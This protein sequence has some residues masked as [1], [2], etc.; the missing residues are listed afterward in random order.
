MEKALK[1]DPELI[2]ASEV[3][4]SMS[5]LHLAAACP[6]AGGVDAVRWLLEKGI[7]W[8][9]KDAKDRIPEDLARMMGNEE[10]CKVLREWAVQKGAVAHI[11]DLN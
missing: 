2:Y 1:K 7:P 4:D 6:K 10:S 11:D 9:A 5:V 3:F 8:S